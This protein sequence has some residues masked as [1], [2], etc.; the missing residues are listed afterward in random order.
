MGVFAFTHHMVCMATGLK[1]LISSAEVTLKPLWKK[2]D[3]DI[4]GL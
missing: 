1:I 4:Q 2:H 3:R